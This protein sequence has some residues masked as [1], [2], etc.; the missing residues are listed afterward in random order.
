[1]V[2][3]PPR[4][5]GPSAP[6]AGAPG[7]TSRPESRARGGSGYAV[8]AGAAVPVAGL[9]AAAVTWRDPHVPGSWGLC[10][11]LVATGTPCP[12]CGGLRAV[13]DLVAG[14]PAEAFGHQPYLVGSLAVGLAMMVAM[15]AA[16]LL[17]SAVRLRASAVSLRASS[18]G[19][20]GAQRHAARS[21]VRSAA[22]RGGRETWYWGAVVGWLL[23]LVLFGV[24][25]ALNP[26]WWPPLGAG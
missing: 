8:L 18:A 14:R 13:A 15:G 9:L 23:G 26:V 2:T 7:S 6:A 19:G 22:R 24:A 5:V 11:W 17:A 4:A 3:R 12:T 16:G 1:M 25:R 20:Q 10:P 21:W